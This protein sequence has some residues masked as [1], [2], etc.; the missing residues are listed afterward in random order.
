V[1]SISFISRELG[2]AAWSSGRILVGSVLALDSFRYPGSA[3]YGAQAEGE[4]LHFIRIRVA[5]VLKGADLAEGRELS[6]FHPQEW[7]QHTHAP[8]L[9]DGVISYVDLHYSGRLHPEEIREGTTLLLFLSAEAV[10]EGFPPGAVFLSMNGA[11]DLAERAGE[12]EA[13]L[14]E[15]PYADFDQSISLKPGGHVRLPDG[16]LVRLLGHSHGPK[17][18]T[19]ELESTL[20]TGAT[21]LRLGRVAESDSS[22]SW[23][24][25]LFGPYTVELRGMDYGR[26]STIVVRSEGRRDASWRRELDEFDDRLKE[27]E[28][29]W[30]RNQLLGRAGG[31]DSFSGDV[32]S[33]CCQEGGRGCVRYSS[34]V[35]TLTKGM[36]THIDRH[37]GHK[38]VESIE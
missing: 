15:G 1:G 11:C 16:L 2:S 19:A 10:P 9:R 34:F 20:G 23:G 17:G 31:P 24:Y 29:G 13:A 38:H 8:L 14:R 36:V 5:R 3:T 21:R 4:A 22:S 6:V 18:E 30:T 35:F 7:F 27:V 12:A 33:Y 28:L 26:E 37:G 25:E 32:W